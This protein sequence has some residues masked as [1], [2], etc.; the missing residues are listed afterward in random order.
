MERHN[1]SPLIENYPD[2]IVA[3]QLSKQ[4]PLIFANEGFFRVIG[5]KKEIFASK[6]I[7]N[8]FANI[9]LEEDL[10]TVQEKISVLLLGDE[11]LVLKCR[12]LDESEN[13]IW[14]FVQGILT[15][16]DNG[17]LEL[18]CIVTDITYDI[19]IQ[20]KVVLEHEKYMALSQLSG[21]ITF[22]YDVINDAV[23]HSQKFYDEFSVRED[24][25]GLDKFKDWEY[26]IHPQDWEEFKKNFYSLKA[27]VSS[28][29]VQVR[30]KT[31]TGQYEWYSLRCMSQ[32]DEDGEVINKIGRITNINQR[33]KELARLREL[34]SSDSLTGLK[35]RR[36]IESEIDSY[37]KKED[38]SNRIFMV[39]DVDEFK[40][41]NDSWGHPFGDSV[42]RYVS[43]E[44]KQRFGNEGL[45]GRIGGDEFV[46]FFTNSY[47]S[48]EVR[49][50]ADNVLSIFSNANIKKDLILSG[51]IG[52]AIVSIQK[53]TYQELFHCA[54]IALY[55][56]KTS[57]KNQYK[58]YE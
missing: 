45:I 35:N 24:G 57:G 31:K 27:K 40:K 12:I 22:T 26:Y 6:P 3:L 47:E 13:V 37:L 34:A 25:T 55:Q 5:Y 10:N 44:L 50:L 54:D 9:I 33:M 46:L 58:I 20:R 56:A 32:F 28:V 2:G 49:R 48:K 51:S 52:I 4:L 39:I 43:M 16:A 29:R 7:S 14:I 53:K 11:R 19:M 18:Q 36:A 38:I 41:I 17:S 21:E 30:L 15:E 23:S 1:F 42:L 8:N